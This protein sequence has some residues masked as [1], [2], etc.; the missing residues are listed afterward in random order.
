MT[1]ARSLVL[2]VSLTTRDQSFLSLHHDF[3]YPVTLRHTVSHGCLLTSMISYQYIHYIDQ[4]VASRAYLI[5]VAAAPPSRRRSS[6]RVR[7][8]TRTEL[9][10]P[11]RALK[12]ITRTA[13]KMHSGFG[14]QAVS[15]ENPWISDSLRYHFLFRN[16]SV[17]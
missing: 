15:I 1:I 11:P 6:S 2:A 13:V 8:G 16:L 17:C 10:T 12:I 4:S 7:S 3:E 14:Y 5:M 9:T